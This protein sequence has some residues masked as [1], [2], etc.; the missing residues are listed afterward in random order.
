MYLG[1]GCDSRPW[2]VSATPLLNGNGGRESFNG[3][4]SRLAGLLEKLTRIC[5]QRLHVLALAFR[6]HG[7]KGKRGLAGS[8]DSGNDNQ[9][10]SGN[11]DIDSP[12]I[13]LLGP[14]D[15]DGFCGTTHEVT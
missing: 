11:L 7:V 5:C 15:D 12:K 10:V 8:R 13:V 2:C 4:E 3:L 6:K 14:L 9:L 1:G